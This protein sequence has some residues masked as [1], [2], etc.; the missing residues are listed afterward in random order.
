M[1]TLDWADVRHFLQVVRSGSATRAAARLGINHTTVYRRIAALE[2]RLGKSLFARSSS[3]WV[4]T[5][6]GERIVAFA[7]SMAEKA[8]NIERQ[9]LADSHELMGFSRRGIGDAEGFDRG[10]AACW[11]GDKWGVSLKSQ[12][13]IPIF[14]SGGF[15]S[16]KLRKT[17]RYKY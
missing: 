9:I 2:D 12:F 5:P 6:V 14:V 11:L 1:R 15:K 3:G 17:G 16:V 8:H 10:E 4:L 7:E 13:V